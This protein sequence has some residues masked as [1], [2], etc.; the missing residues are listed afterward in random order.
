[1]QQPQSIPEST[2]ALL[3][4][5]GFLFMGWF[6]I[7]HIGHVER[8]VRRRMLQNFVYRLYE[9][10]R[11]FAA[12]VRGVDAF[13]DAYYTVQTKNKIAPINERKFTP[14]RVEDPKPQPKLEPAPVN[15]MRGW[16]W[17]KFRREQPQEAASA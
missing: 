4:L 3:C 5:I 14:V 10:Q 6:L 9:Y 16:N 13:V 7:R 8:N 11:W 1:M 17:K 12:V 2:L 15:I